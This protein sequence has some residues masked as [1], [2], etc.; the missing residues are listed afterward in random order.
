[1][2]DAA[3]SRVY[4]VIYEVKEV[5]TMTTIYLIRHAQAD[6]NLYRRCQAWYDGLVTQTGYRQIEALEQRFS[7]AHIDA[8]YSSDLFRTMTTAKAI[9]GPRGLPLNTDPDLREIRSGCW[10][11]RTW[12]ELLKTER[13]S[14]LAFWRCDPSWKV[15][16]GETFEEVQRR[17]DGAVKRI[18]AAHPNQTIAIF[19]HGCVIRSTLAHWL[20]LPP[21]RIHEIPHGDNTSVAKLEYDNNAINVCWYN[22]VSHLS[23]E[24]AHAP[25]PSAESDEATA[26]GIESSS[27]YFIPMDLPRTQEIYLEAR[28]NAWMVSHGSMDGFDGKTFLRA[29]MACYEDAPDSILA[30]VLNGTPV[31]ILQMDY[32]TEAELGVGRVPFLCLTP[33]IRD[34][35]LGVQLLGQAVSTYRRLG[36]QYI[37]LRCA[38]ENEKA[39]HFYKRYG[40][41]KIGEEPGGTGHLD[42][43]EKYIGYDHP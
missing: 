26:A 35:G 43:L 32:R 21:Q 10:E 4:Y 40:F 36:R 20:G 25:H 22:D 37:R 6:G 33:H 13:E 19:A 2:P 24:L 39:Q 27:L 42:T 1:M 29:A 16:G 34:H 12:G 14:L 8:V 30:A 28:E 17:F 18:A 9:Y 15:E 38:P 11:D 7:G 3:G 41:Y 23:G 31:G 5:R